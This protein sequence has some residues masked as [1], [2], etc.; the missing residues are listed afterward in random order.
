MLSSKN[1]RINTTPT[2]FPANKQKHCRRSTKKKFEA[3]RENKQSSNK[4]IDFQL[5]IPKSGGEKKSM[6]STKSREKTQ[7]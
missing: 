4:F 6:G 3:R 7:K 1:I 5:T 2:G